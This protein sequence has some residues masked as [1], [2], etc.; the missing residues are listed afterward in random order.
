MYTVPYTC[1]CSQQVWRCKKCCPKVVWCPQWNPG[2]WKWFCRSAKERN[3]ECVDLVVVVVMVRWRIYFVIY[4]GWNNTSLG[5]LEEITLWLCIVV[6]IIMIIPS[7]FLLIYYYLTFF[8]DMTEYFLSVLFKCLWGEEVQTIKGG[9]LSL[10][11]V[12]VQKKGRYIHS[13]C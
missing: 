3:C 4:W 9:R 10:I 11:L 12:V 13:V 1:V 7:L 6:R 5:N 8:Y 2:T